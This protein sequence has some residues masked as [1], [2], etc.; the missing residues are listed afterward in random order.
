MINKPPPLNRDYDRDPNVYA[1]KRRGV[2]NHVSTL[3]VEV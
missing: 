2:L 3:W 1:L